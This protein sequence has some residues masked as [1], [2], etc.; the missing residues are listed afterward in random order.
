M[1][2]RDYPITIEAGAT[3]R[4]ELRLLDSTGAAMDLT[5]KTFSGQVRAGSSRGALLATFD[6][7]PSQVAQGVVAWT[8]SADQTALIDGAAVY[9]VEMHSADGS[10]DRLL[11]GF[12]LVDPEVTR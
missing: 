6:F 9:S 2:A 5:G 12:V 10:V 11:K 4:R 1:P 3:F 8:L 7:T